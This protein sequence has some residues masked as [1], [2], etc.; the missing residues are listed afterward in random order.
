MS[1]NVIFLFFSWKHGPKTFS[2]FQ[3][4]SVQEVP[5]LLNGDSS[6][7]QQQRSLPSSQSDTCPTQGSPQTFSSASSTGGA[8]GGSS[9]A[10]SPQH[11]ST[12]LSA[13]ASPLPNSIA[14]GS[15]SPAAST[16]TTS[17]SSAQQSPLPLATNTSSLSPS[18]IPSTVMSHSQISPASSSLQGMTLPIPHG[19]PRSPPLPHS[20]PL[21]RSMTPVQLLHQQ[22]GPGGSNTLSPSH[23]PW[24]Q[25]SA[26]MCATATLPLPRR[27][28]SEMRLGGF[29]GKK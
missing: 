29:Q 27:P 24:L 3:R 13:S 23:N 2:F 6:R 19:A 7:S 22:V 9:R 10:E 17:S 26:D 5:P 16:P 11:T 8:A 20:A 18:L 15:P 12:P 28:V 21:S 14:S 4:L 25:K 1:C